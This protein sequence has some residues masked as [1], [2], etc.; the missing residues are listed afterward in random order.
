MAITRSSAAERERAG[1]VDPTQRLTR[2]LELTLLLLIALLL[3]G[4]VWLV[5]AARAPELGVAEDLRAHGKLLD[6]NQ[7]RSPDELLPALAF[8]DNPGDRNFAARHIIEFLRDREQI[9]SVSDLRLIQVTSSQVEGTRG[10]S[11]FPARLKEI[12]RSVADETIIRGAGNVAGQSTDRRPVSFPLLTPAQLQQLRPALSV[13]TAYDFRR[14][15]VIYTVV[16]V[17]AFLLLHAAWRMRLFAGDQLLLPPVFLLSGFG[18]LMMIRL[19]DPIREALLFPDF[20]VGVAIGCVCAFLASLPD[21]DR[22]ALRRLAFIPLL[23]SFLLSLVVI[24][25]GS[26]PGVSDAKVNLRLGPILLQPVEFI[27]VLLILFLAGFFADRWEFLREL[28]A[29]SRT[30]PPVL[31]GF[32][33]P[34]LRYA[35]PLVVAVGLAIAFFFLEKDLGPALVLT[36][37]FLMLYA[38]ARSRVTG[39]LIALVALIG[40]FAIG[41]K[42]GVPHTVANRV[43]MWLSPWDNYIAHGG[44]HLAHSFWSFSTGGV[45]G[46]GLGLGNPGSVPAVHTDLILAAIG[47]ELGFVGLLCVFLAYAVLIHRALRISLA[48]R[49]SYS[50][51]LGLGMALLIAL[52]VA[53]IAAG[54]LGLAPLSGVVT[55]YINYGKSSMAINFVILGVLAALSAHSGRQPDEPFRAQVRWTGALLGVL[56]L[57][58]LGQAARVQVVEADRFLGRGA[59][60]PQADGHRRY[61]Y[62]SR[63]L[64]A[65]QSIPRGSIFDRNGIPLA[66]NSQALLESYRAQYDQMHVNLDSALRNGS[67]RMYPLG[68]LTFH[69]LGDLPSRL[70]WG[71]PNTSFVERDMNTKLQGYD[72]R[73]M[74][75]RVRDKPGGPEHLVLRRDF[76]ELLPLVRYRYR[77]GDKRVQE[78]L[79]RD[80]DVHLT[81][82]ARMQAKLA[83][84]MEKHIQAA[85]VQRG[86]AIVIDPSTGD[87]LASITYP[88]ADA[89]KATEIVARGEDLPP[90]IIDSLLDRPRYGMYPPGSSFKLLTTIA[91][92][93]TPDKVENISYECKRLPDGRVGNYVRGWGRPIRDDVL[94]TIPHG[95]VDLAK[96]LI[97]SCNAYFAQLGT[98]VVGAERLLQTAD[99]FGIKVA[100]PNTAAKLKDALPQASYGQGQVVASPLEMARVAGSIANDGML[101]PSRWVVDQVPPSTQVCLPPEQAR[102]LAGFMRRVVTEG[103]GQAARSAAVAIAGKTGT[104][105]LRDKPAH[106]WFVGFAPY[107]SGAKRI[108]FAIIMENARYGGRVAAPIAPDIVAAALDTGLIKQE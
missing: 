10:L 26:G 76:R 42:L 40:A 101:V 12:R 87:L 99:L 80:R 88:W 108:A 73:A 74:V 39:A 72:D 27:K 47:E 92:L 31:R 59:L 6:V 8:F 49:G 17:L 102:E 23:A 18:L 62:N 64:E 63:I 46:T 57:V 68:A 4:G 98:Y 77:P 104:A 38:V 13:R 79:Q 16:F 69:I 44:D 97:V 55:P 32:N 29:P 94:D 28:H 95:T 71:A 45:F 15:V 91:A 3:A 86:A 89:A 34:R 90:D 5:L 24:V 21:Y 36:L 66:S 11:V 20:A 19:R 51:F 52:Q 7:L 105:E 53:F 78:I 58:I 106:A 103:T 84:I 100:A 35:L 33:L 107:E 22:S 83:A 25:F 14:Q 43:S 2:G 54:I 37:L 85:K 60:V 61:A 75:V 81:L 41:Y 93:K 9:G 70:N 1:R 82:D 30:L 56:G 65:A 96:G 50:F 67:T 48:G